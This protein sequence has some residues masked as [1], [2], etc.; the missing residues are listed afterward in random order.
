MT[1]DQTTYTV[2]DWI[3]YLKKC[4]EEQSVEIDYKNCLE[5]A[6]ML[7]NQ[8]KKLIECMKHDCWLDN[9][10]TDEDICLECGE[11]KDWCICHM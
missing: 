9:Q 7:E 6:Y 8:H 4:Y 1:K 11:H 10:E 5:I 3:K 2:I